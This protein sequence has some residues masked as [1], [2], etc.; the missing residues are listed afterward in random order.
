[1]RHR[2][3]AAALAIALLGRPA[4]AGPVED[5]SVWLDADA[6]AVVRIEAGQI[7]QAAGLLRSSGLP[8]MFETITMLSAG[9]AFALGFDPMAKTGWFAGGL[10]GDV[11]LLASVAAIDRGAVD[12]IVAARGSSDR[13]VLWRTRAVLKLDDPAKGGR[14]LTALLGL[15]SGGVE[16]SPGNGA[17]LAGMLGGATGDGNAVV[18]ELRAAGVLAVARVP[19]VDGVLLLH[20]HGDVAVLDLVA[21]YAGVPLDWKRDRAALRALLAR[22]PGG[23]GARLGRGAGTLLTRAGTVI[24][25]DTVRLA[26][27]WAARQREEAVRLV[28]SGHL[29]PAELRPAPPS[30]ADLDVLAASGPFEDLAV[31]VTFRGGGRQLR[32]TAAVSWTLRPGSKLAPALAVADDLLIDPL[33]LA[34]SRGAAAA[35]A[36]Y[37]RG[38]GGLRAL[39]RPPLLAGADKLEAAEPACG[40]HTAELVRA[41]AWPQVIGMHADDIAAVHRDA[42]RAIASLRNA[43]FAV[44]NASL[45]PKQLEGVVTASVDPGAVPLVDGWL[46]LVFGAHGELPAKDRQPARRLWSEGPLRPWR[47]RVAGPGLYGA[48]LGGAREWYTAQNRPARAARPE[49]VAEALGD[50]SRIWDQAGPTLPAWMADGKALWKRARGFA[51]TVR[52]G[53][54]TIDAVV[55][56][57]L[58]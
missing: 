52:L 36:V 22:K 19:R 7:E 48:A 9:S 25:M 58:H 4:H 40:E 33:D 49:L 42:D 17:A 47:L 37:L 11:P 20:R 8:G 15:A 2:L 57:E 34:R 14:S 6:A 18:T 23:P 29:R 43:G 5:L 45:D 38:L 53:T 28:R 39:P 26:A 32:M 50:V 13:P 30:C 41:L 16:V 21:P 10:D 44:R 27:S 56:V 51:L 3:A 1:V 12:R 54:D 35:G 55:D 31:S 24:W 46:D